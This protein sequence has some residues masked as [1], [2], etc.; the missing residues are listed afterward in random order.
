ML[1]G[2][3][4]S[5]DGKWIATVVAEAGVTPLYKIPVDGGDPVRLVDDGSEGVLSQPGWSPDGKLILHEALESSKGI[6]L[7]AVTP[8][9]NVVRV[10]GL[11]SWSLGTPYWFMPDSSALVL[12]LG[13]DVPTFDVRSRDFW[14]LD[15]SSGER[16]RLAEMKPGFGVNAFDVSPDGR[17]IIFDSAHARTRT[18]C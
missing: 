3:A 5:P 7:R 18:S 16:R 10:P 4:L 17:Q 1:G 8:E 12:L 13:S 6:H 2:P 9:G 11:E 14:L 15:L